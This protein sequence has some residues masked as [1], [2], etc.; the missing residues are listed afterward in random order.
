MLVTFYSLPW[1]RFATRSHWS[2]LLP[3]H[4]NQDCTL[5]MLV[6]S[7]GHNIWKQL[8]VTI[9]GNTRC[10]RSMVMIVGHDRWSWSLNKIIGHDCWSRS[11]VTIAGCDHWTRSLAMMAGHYQWLYW[12]VVMAGCGDWSRPHPSP[13]SLGA[14]AGRFYQRLSSV[15]PTLPLARLV[16]LPPCSP[17]FL[18]VP[19]LRPC[20]ASLLLAL[21]YLLF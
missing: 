18:I 7:T 19:A 1:G 14:L 11:L 8:L 4:I 10:S 2:R 16:I 13:L 21:A 6:K 5:L 3:T 20:S 12:L 9:A 17:F 15:G